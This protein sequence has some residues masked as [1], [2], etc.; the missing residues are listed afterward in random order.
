MIYNKY[1][2]CDE[3]VLVITKDF[4]SQLTPLNVEDFKNALLVCKALDAMLFFN[5]GFN[6][7]ASIKHKHMQVIPY[8]GFTG[9]VLP[10][11]VAAQSYYHTLGEKVDSF[12]LPVMSKIKHRFL[13][14]NQ[15]GI[16]FLADG[17]PSEEFD[18]DS[19]LTS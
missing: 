7:G 16:G 9:Q 13:A 1:C 12:E 14:L 8:K 11:E 2:V 19:L 17:F 4:Q 15:V 5:C 10:I 6:S 18:P 3:H